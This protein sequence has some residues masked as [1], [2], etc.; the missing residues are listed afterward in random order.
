MSSVAQMLF[1]TFS[2]ILAQSEIIAQRL[3]CFTS[4]DKVEVMPNLKFA[5]KPLPYDQRNL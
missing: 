2:K 1:G 4:H 3:K 5:A